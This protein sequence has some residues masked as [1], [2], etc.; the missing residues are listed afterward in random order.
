MP[1]TDPHRPPLMTRLAAAMHGEISAVTVE[2]YRRAGAAAYQD[3]LAADQVRAEMAAAGTSLWASSAGQ[4]SQLLCT[5]NA[6]VLQTLGDELVEADYRASPGTAGYL[7]RVTAEQASAFLGEVESWSAR[8]RRA[9]A[10]P[11]YDVSAEITLPAQL[12]AWVEVEP[13]PPAHLAA[14]L[15]AGRAV[16]GRAE[17]ALAD[18]SRAGTPAG[19]EKAASRLAGMAADAA[20]VLSYGESMW[21]PAAPQEVHQQAENSL[22]RGIAAYYLLGQL[23]AMPGLLDHAGAGHASPAGQL[24]P[25]PGQP[26]FDPWCL[27]DP[28][29]RASW[30]RDPAA[31]RAV[32]ALWRYDPDPAG[33]LAIQ[34]QIDAALRDGSIVAGVT[35]DGRRIG[36]YFCC[37]W[38]AIYLARRPVVI[39]GRRLRAMQQFTFDVS[40]EEMAEGGQFKRDLLLGPFHPTYEVDY[41][42]PAAVGD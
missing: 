35:A 25:M 7:P 6:F 5:W 4:A 23:L 41:C 31:R 29:S 17:A 15:A 26:G 2:A 3:M 30:R 20:S 37:P 19:Q 8:S 28:A 21:S 18:F 22:K 42:D 14:M 9:A 10:D 13:C 27:T 11:A 40:A 1:A 24:L 38:S 34:A 39:A 12:P 32:G 16:R 36:N 33:T